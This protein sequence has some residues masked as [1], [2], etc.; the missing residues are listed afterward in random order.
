VGVKTPKS[1][2]LAKKVG[3]WPFPFSKVGRAFEAT[4]GKTPIENRLF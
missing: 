4:C 3:K 1:L 2:K